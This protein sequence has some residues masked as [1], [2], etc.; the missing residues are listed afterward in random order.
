MSDLVTRLG[1]ISSRSLKTSWIFVL[2]GSHTDA[3]LILLVTLYVNSYSIVYSL[4][5]SLKVLL[6]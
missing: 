6:S 4:L 5:I 2:L 3:T 1:P